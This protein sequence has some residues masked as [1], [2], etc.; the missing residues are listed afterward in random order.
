M[1][2]RGPKPPRTPVDAASRRACQLRRVSGKG[3]H[4]ALFSGVADTQ[5]D[6]LRARQIARKPIL[7]F[8]VKL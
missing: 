8:P 4:T 3:R 5:A 6:Y 2:R 7:W 1:A